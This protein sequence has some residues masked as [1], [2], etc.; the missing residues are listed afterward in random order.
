MPRLW[1]THRTD[2]LPWLAT[3][4]GRIMAEYSYLEWQFEEIIR[5]LLETDIKRARIA[6]TGMNMRTRATVAASLANALILPMV[7]DL[8][9]LGRDAEALKSE[10]DKYAHGLWGKVASRWLVTRVSGSRTRDGKTITRAFLPTGEI[11]TRANVASIRKRL[12]TAH[13]NARVIRKGLQAALSPSPYKRPEKF[14]QTGRRLGQRKTGRARQR[15][16]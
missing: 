13:G 3:A 8:E 7:D 1:L 10:R 9:K 11:I 14:R 15:G 4:I 12:R 16:S 2:I 5:L 6:V